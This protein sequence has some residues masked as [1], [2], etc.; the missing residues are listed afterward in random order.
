MN[1]ATRCSLLTL[2]R[3]E[4]LKINTV[5]ALGLRTLCTTSFICTRWFSV[6]HAGAYRTQGTNPKC[7]YMRPAGIAK[8]HRNITPEAM[9]GHEHTTARF[10]RS[11]SNDDTDDDDD[12]NNNNNIM[13]TC[14]M[15]ISSLCRSWLVT[16]Y[17][18]KHEVVTSA[19][20]VKKKIG[21]GTHRVTQ[22]SIG[23]GGGVSGTA[24]NIMNY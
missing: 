5:S 11:R 3:E 14:T 19:I 23:R 22:N 13:G 6:F 4:H 10:E 9:R 7:S 8:T 21:F 15:C 17:A 16:Q 24:Q 20:F 1:G 18:R 12:N 2:E